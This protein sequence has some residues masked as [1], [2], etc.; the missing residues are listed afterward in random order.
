MSFAT[1]IWVQRSRHR[2]ERELTDLRASY[3]RELETLR[4]ALAQK[5]DEATRSDEAQRLVNRY[6][7]PLPR[8]AFD[9]Q[10]RI[11]NI[12]RGG[13]RRYPHYTRL[14]TLFVLAQFLGWLEIVRREMQF[15]DLGAAPTTRDLNRNLEKVT[16]ILSSQSSTDDF[17]LYRG[18]QRAIGEIMLSPVQT[19]STPLGPRHDCIGYAEFVR[20]QDD[21]QFTRWF[22]RLD[23]AVQRLQQ[24]RSAPRR[25][26]EAQRALMDLVDHLDP[27]H[28]RLPGRRTRLRPPDRRLGQ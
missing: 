18:H 20:R 6:R 5:R 13:F 28:E 2:A 1:A 12:L 11:F 16:E 3:D 17:Y 10:S 7:D 24:Q 25:L 19:S 8:A 26:I 22:E 15:L 27:D 14:Y 9:L 4:D 21:P 23:Q